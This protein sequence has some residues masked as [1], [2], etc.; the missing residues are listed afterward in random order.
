MALKATEIKNL[1][2]ILQI[3]LA[4]ARDHCLQKVGF[5]VATNHKQITKI[6]DK[7]FDTSPPGTSIPTN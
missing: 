4:K 3:S 5:V 7:V 2:L 6:H 1:K